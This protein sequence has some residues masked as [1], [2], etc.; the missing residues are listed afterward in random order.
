MMILDIIT[1]SFSLPEKIIGFSIS[2]F[3]FV[4]LVADQNNS[5]C[6]VFRLFWVLELT[7]IKKGC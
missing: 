7:Y 1:A 6:L 4:N 2:A 3:Y 5:Q